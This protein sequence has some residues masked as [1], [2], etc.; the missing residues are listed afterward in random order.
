MIA[1]VVSAG[2][3]VTNNAVLEAYSLGVET[4]INYV[5]NIQWKMWPSG[6]SSHSEETSLGMQGEVL[7][8]SDI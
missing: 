6:K 8:E 3:P 4:D 5:M 1:T 2:N 7:V